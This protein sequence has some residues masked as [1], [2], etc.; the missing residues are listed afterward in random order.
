MPFSSKKSKEMS[1][2]QKKELIKK[3]YNLGKEV[4]YHKHFEMGWVLDKYNEMNDIAVEYGF[5]EQIKRY[6]EK[7]KEDGSL[8]RRVDVG[9]GMSKKIEPPPKIKEEEKKIATEPKEEEKRREPY[10]SVKVNK[11]EIVKPI[12]KRGRVKYVEPAY[13]Q[14]KKPDMISSPKFVERTESIDLPT[15][16]EAFKLLKRTK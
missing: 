2:A 10:A 4:G 13:T 14:T 3:A 1:A 12:D 9:V 8:R 5:E 6:Y 7:G 15:F 16:L 11:E